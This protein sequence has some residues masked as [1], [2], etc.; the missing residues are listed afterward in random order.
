ALKV[1]WH[2]LR[3]A[4]SDDCAAMTL[5]KDAHR[6]ICRQQTTCASGGGAERV[7]AGHGSRTRAPRRRGP[8]T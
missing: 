1:W 4:T 3:G 7:R 5:R 8:R 2:A 6:S